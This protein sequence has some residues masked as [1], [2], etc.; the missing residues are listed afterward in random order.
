MKIWHMSSQTSSNAKQYCTTWINLQYIM[1]ATWIKWKCWDK[2]FYNPL[3]QISNV[4]FMTCIYSCLKCIDALRNSLTDSTLNPKVKIIQGVGLCS[5][6]PSTLGV[7]R[8]CWNYGMR[9]MMSDK[10]VDYSHGLT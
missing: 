8:M 4:K 2:I 1:I 3:Q 9:T 7:R 6:A 5:L 10:W